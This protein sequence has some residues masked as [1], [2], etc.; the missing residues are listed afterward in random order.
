[1]DNEINSIY[2]NYLARKCFSTPFESIDRGMKD[3]ERMKTAL[4]INVEI[5]L[6]GRS[7]RLKLKA[8]PDGGGNAQIIKEEVMLFRKIKSPR[9][10]DTWTFP[11]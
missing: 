11:N 7:K 1:L 4:R 2:D 9:I 6:R 10:R 8:W 3:V 5:L